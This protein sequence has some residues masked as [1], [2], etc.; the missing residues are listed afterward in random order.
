M[1]DTSIKETKVPPFE[2][3]LRIRP[4]HEY[5]YNNL[6]Q[7][8]LSLIK[9]YIKVDANEEILNILDPS[10]KEYFIK[11]ERN[12][13]FDGIF[14][15]NQDNFKIS[16]KL[17]FKIVNNLLN[18]INS[19]I[20][21]YGVT[22]SGKT[23]TMFGDIYEEIN[24]EKGICTSTL[25]YLFESLENRKNTEFKTKISYLEIYNEQVIDLLY[26]E[27]N[28][29]QQFNL[30]NN[31]FISKKESLMII[32]DAIKGIIVPN[33]NEFYIKSI[34]EV[35]EYILKGNKK[36]TMA[37][38]GSNQ[39]SSRSH[40]ILILVLEQI[41][42]NKK[43][44][45]KFLLVDLAGSE[46]GGL[47]KGI[48][49]QEGS[50]I[51]K[52]LLALG[53]CINILSDKSK[54]G[55]F[56]PYRDSKLTRLLKDSLGG[57]ISTVMISCISP[58][59]LNY[60]ETINTLK[61]SSKARNIEKQI[62]KN[63][64]KEDLQSYQYKEIIESLK[65]EIDQL[66][67][68]LKQYNYNLLSQKNIK[69]K[70]YYEVNDSFISKNIDKIKTNENYN[71]FIGKEVDSMINLTIKERNEEFDYLDQSK[72]NSY[73]EKNYIEDILNTNMNDI[74]SLDELIAINKK[75]EAINS[76][77]QNLDTQIENELK[78]NSNKAKLNCLQNKYSYVTYFYDKL[79]E[80][81]NNQLIEN[82]EKGLMLNSNLLE[83]KE[84]NEQN[85]QKISEQNIPSSEA[86][87]L[88]EN[89]EENKK[90]NKKIEE[91]IS[92]NQ[93]LKSF[94]K[95]LIFKLNTNNELVN[96][97]NLQVFV[98]TIQ[99]EKSQSEENNK[100][101]IE[102]NKK[103]EMEL[104][105]KENEILQLKKEIENLKNIKPSV[106]ININ[107]NNK[108]TSPLSVYV[109]LHK[110]IEKE[111]KDMNK[112]Y[113][114][115]NLFSDS[116]KVNLLEEKNNNV[117][118]QLNRKENKFFSFNEN[119]QNK[120]NTE[121]LFKSKGKVITKSFIINKQ[122]VK[123]NISIS[124]LSNV[125]NVYDHDISNSELKDVSQILYPDR[126]KNENETS[127]LGRNIRNNSMNYQRTSN[128]SNTNITSL[129]KYIDNFLKERQYDKK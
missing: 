53:N 126:D 55:S 123:D 84:L 63:I 82:I 102:K 99:K 77:K 85:T 96:L 67:K 39:F 14:T 47:E 16:E 68:M 38:T 108:I 9:D 50:K 91:M 75:L 71:D 60:D 57:N 122:H 129:N 54:E 100:I 78:S 69:S 105:I 89:I 74:E 56:V 51:N 120:N 1:V 2:V 58:N 66:K 5:E 119:R 97:N 46:R 72:N 40:A 26:E 111:S 33:L 20:L 95:D 25:E 125:S 43:V 7:N 92:L 86:N 28:K 48:R 79:A 6:Q 70:E 35:I 18:G 106:N 12:F 15:E 11:K 107:N 8:Y 83:I 93:E 42:D 94:L 76:Y 37:A 121:G 23:Y 65:N 88:L 80:Q 32:E 31:Q 29:S 127:N 10:T 34:E 124:A 4:F 61:Y 103:L 44:T 64:L 13:N 17:K 62:K 49:T 114:E 22:G 116:C 45:S 115:K 27:S 113:S 112:N 19:T 52:S 109:D 87:I 59:P 90:T 73:L 21:T 104:D 24:I 41:I 118:L 30:F 81:A 36:R 3:Y 98:Q 110:Y 128:K 101:L 117:H